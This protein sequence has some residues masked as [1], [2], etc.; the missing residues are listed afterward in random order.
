MRGKPAAR[1]WR[2][3][4]IRDTML[5][6]AVTGTPV[7]FLDGVRY[8]TAPNKYSTHTVTVEEVRDVIVRPGGEP[9]RSA[10]GTCLVRLKAVT[11]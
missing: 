9:D 8:A 7:T 4:Q 6:L 10:E 2:A 3:E 5:T 1:S 11:T